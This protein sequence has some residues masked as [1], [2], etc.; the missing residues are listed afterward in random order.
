MS[1]T[2]WKPEPRPVPE[3]LDEHYEARHYGDITRFP[4]IADKLDAATIWQL[5]ELTRGGIGEPEHD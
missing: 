2:S 5:R 3:E 1:D 4:T